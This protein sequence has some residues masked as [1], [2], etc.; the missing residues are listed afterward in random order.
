MIVVGIDE[1]GR[2]CWAGPLVAGAVVLR[3]PVEGLKDSKKLSKLRREKLAQKI[4]ENADV[5][6]GWV[7][8]SEVDGL[9][10]TES[11]RLA[12]SRALEQ[13]SAD[14]D[15]IIIDGNLNFFPDDPRAR[16]II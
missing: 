9:G 3:T 5:G 15:E 8:A 1:V 10:L 7:S 16:A 6:L 11:V 14:F 12:M 2:G 4:Y 13:I